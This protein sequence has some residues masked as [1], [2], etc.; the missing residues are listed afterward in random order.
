MVT[1]GRCGW[2]SSTQRHGGTEMSQ[3]PTSSQITQWRD[4]IGAPSAR[5]QD[6]KPT[7]LPLNHENP[8]ALRFPVLNET[9][10]IPAAEE[11]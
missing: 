6:R 9:T 1:S 11:A 5:Q 3:A 7:R 10:G 2:S 4:W 8:C